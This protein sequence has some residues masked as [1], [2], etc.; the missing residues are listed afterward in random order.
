M[1]GSLVTRLVETLWSWRF[2][3]GVVGYFAVLV[4]LTAHASSLAVAMAVLVAVLGVGLSFRQPRRALAAMLRRSRVRRQWAGAVRLGLPGLGGRV[5][6]V[7]SSRQ[8]PA[9][10]MLH[11]RV[12]AGACAADLAAGAEPLAAVLGVRE[13]RVDRDPAHAGR[14]RVLVVRRDP[15]IDAEGVS[16]P[17]REAFELSAWR[18]IPVGV[19]EDGQPV[20]ISLPERNVL[21]GGEP[22]AGK[23]AALAPLVATVALDPTAALWVLDGKLVE[24]ATWAGCARHTVGADVDEAIDVL[25]TLRRE[26]DSR[27]GELLANRARK[28]TAAMDL[29]LHVVVI[30]ELAFYLTTGDRK[31]RQTFADVLRDVVARGRAAGI[32]VLA[33]TQKPSSDIIPTSLRDLF[34]FRWALRCSTPQASD[35]VLGSGW[36]S[37]GYN[38]A[39]VDAAHRG[40]GYLLHEG[41]FPT[42]LRSYYLDDADL[43]SL[44]VRAEALRAAT[45]SFSIPSSPEVVR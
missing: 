19:G 5:P 43:D 29:P 41:G 7:L 20:T 33:A 9:G 13:V 28:I 44:S 25:T 21:L 3:L 26:M 27:Y 30:D 37:A 4:W 2:E 12:P 14:A 17:H 6:H 38:A 45:A 18:P 36:A 10:D 1:Y 16:W 23:S 15:L 11:V 24:L 22:G 35:T 42:R 39:T 34:G 8:V 31:E 32:V 40:I